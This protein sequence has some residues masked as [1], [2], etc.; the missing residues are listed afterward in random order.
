M[1][2]FAPHRLWCAAL[3][4][5]LALLFG[6]GQI[7]DYAHESLTQENAILMERQRELTTTLRQGRDDAATAQRLSESLGEGE[8]E[9]YLAPSDRVKTAATFEPLAQASRFGAFTYSLS[10]ERPAAL[11]SLENGA[12]VES[13]LTLQ[14]TVP[15]DI[16]VRQFFE[17]LGEN[18][19][20][21]LQIQHLRLERL[22]T[23][24]PAAL[25]L[26]ME[27]QAQWLS[28]GGGLS[29]ATP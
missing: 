8:M 3:L 29:E 24:Q 10:P 15:H 27:A 14:A 9:K 17:R 4:C 26:R 6:S 5:A 1:S 16:A 12:V 18:M 19:A 28:N 13:L 22:A 21:R 23:D 25:N 7:L 2:K 20:G 11:E